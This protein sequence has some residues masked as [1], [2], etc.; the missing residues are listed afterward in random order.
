MPEAKKS[1]LIKTTT[2]SI[3]DTAKTTSD[4]K[5]DKKE[6][7]KVVTPPTPAVKK[8]PVVKP[9]PLAVEEKPV[10]V[11]VKKIEEKK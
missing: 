7:K 5:E 6:E 1:G 4:K 10:K 11:A 9:T 3:H 8:T 2:N